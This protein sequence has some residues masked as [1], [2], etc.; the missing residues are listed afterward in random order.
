MVCSPY[1]SVLLGLVQC[2]AEQR[3]QGIYLQPGADDA[4]PTDDSRS[5][6]ADVGLAGNVVKVNPAF[7]CAVGGCH[8]ALGAQNGAVLALI[9]QGGQHTFQRRAV[10]A[11]GRLGT[12]A[13]EHLVGIVVMV[14]V[15]LVVVVAAAAAALVLILILILILI[16]V[17]MVMMLML[18]VVI[19]IFVMMVV[20]LMLIMVILILVVMVVML[21]LV[22]IVLLGGKAGQLC[23]QRVAALHCLAQLVAGQLVPRCGDNDSRSIVCAEQFDRFLALTAPYANA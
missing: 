18:I 7:A 3:G 14:M 2:Y 19:L 17:M 1:A 21:M 20:M 5:T 15:S 23:L 11:D 22:L 6:R 16:P 4:Q 12:A 9:T 8:N 13:Y 10:K